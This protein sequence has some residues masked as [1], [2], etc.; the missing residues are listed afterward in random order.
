LE[1]AIYQSGATL[2]VVTQ[3]RLD[4]ELVKRYYQIPD[5]KIRTIHNGV[6]IQSFHPGLRKESAAVRD[7]LGL[8]ADEPLLVFASMDFEGKGL[9]TLLKAMA[10]THH[11][12]CRLLVLGTGPARKFQ[13]IATDLGVSPRVIFAGRR[14]DIA[15][16]YAAGD[17]FLLPT[18]YEPFPNVILEAMACGLPVVTTPTS[19]GADILDQGK[20]GYLVSDVHATEEMKEALNHHF[21]LPETKRREMSAHCWATAQQMTIETNIAKT[22]EMFEEVLHEKFRA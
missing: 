18:A 21:D 4:R 15:R 5:E 3:S 1:R 20:N 11:Q 16:F 10:E 14:S 17:L 13:R 22:L 19:G 8:G 12:S 9:R 6:D 2:R 7:Q